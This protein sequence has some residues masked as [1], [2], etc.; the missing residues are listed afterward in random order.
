MDAMRIH[1]KPEFLNR[2][3]E[4]ILFNRLTRENLR[5]IT[6]LRI[7]ELATLLAE[8]KIELDVTDA[9][10]GQ[11]AE[12]GFDPAYGARPLNRLIR[13]E[14]QNKLAGE[15]LKGNFREGDTVTIDVENGDF[16]FNKK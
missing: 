4:I 12:K 7:A 16:K 13:R 8:T 9:A 14:L 5:D 3:D 11:L 2:L 6:D 1:F 10:R 15:I